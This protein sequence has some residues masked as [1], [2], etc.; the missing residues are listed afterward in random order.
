MTQSEKTHTLAVSLATYN[1]ATGRATPKNVG[2]FM[3][4]GFETL[5]E[6]CRLRGLPYFA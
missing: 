3:R 6:L 2:R 4:M 1:S 5:N